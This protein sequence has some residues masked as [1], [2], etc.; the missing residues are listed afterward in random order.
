MMLTG[1]RPSNREDLIRD[2][3]DS[4]DFRTYSNRFLAVIQEDSDLTT[5][6][7][8]PEMVLHGEPI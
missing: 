2:S 4:G 1:I 8:E 3:E 7:R 5:E 6:V